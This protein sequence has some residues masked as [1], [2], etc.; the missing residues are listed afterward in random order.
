MKR[1]E[2]IS[3]IATKPIVTEEHG[4]WIYYGFAADAK[5]ST[6]EYNFL[7]CAGI[8]PFSATSGEK[9]GPAIS[10][11]FDLSPLK[12]VIL[13]LAKEQAEKPAENELESW[14]QYCEW[15]GIN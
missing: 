7:C 13:R 5:P 9:T 1:N 6:H 11:L 15:E 4:K 12:T 8:R 2:A 14:A 3:Q 10:A